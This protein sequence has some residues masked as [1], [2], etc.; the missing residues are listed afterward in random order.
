[1]P[2]NHEVNES[3]TPYNVSG[4]HAL[5]ADSIMADA[6][7]LI[8]AIREPGETMGKPEVV[9]AYLRLKLAPLE[10]EVFWVLLF[11]VKNRLLH[12]QEIARGTLSEVHVYPR[13][14]A[15]LALQWNA[16][17]IMVAHNHPSGTSD[18]SDADLRLTNTLKQALDL[19]NIRVLDHFVVTVNDVHSFAEHGQL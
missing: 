17:A 16:A 12:E 11:D 3:L 7:R 10:H 18:P 6:Q 2:K 15:K 9:K 5:T 4:F 8:R 19:F 13:E 14:V 1:M